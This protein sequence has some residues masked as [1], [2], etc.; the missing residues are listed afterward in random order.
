[1]SIFLSRHIEER[2]LQSEP[3]TKAVADRIYPTD[4]V[5][6]VTKYPY[7]AFM[8]S[9]DGV[10]YTKDGPLADTCTATVNVVSK[11]FENSME[12]A[13]EV[14]KALEGVR[15]RYDNFA[16]REAR[17]SSGKPDYISAIDAYV[18]TLNFA[19]TTIK[20]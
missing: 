12:V 20:K 11:S 8:C 9:V 2:L 4:V 18:F 19:M 16:V 13:D 1:M 6:G 5:E 7:I 17:L 10:E 15:A 14:R 3:I